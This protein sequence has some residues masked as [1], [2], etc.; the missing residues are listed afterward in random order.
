MSDGR[1]SVKRV[2]PYPFEVSLQVAGHPM[3]VQIVKVTLKG[4]L[5]EMGKNVVKVGNEGQAQFALPVLRNIVAASIKVMRTYDQFRQLKDQPKKHEVIRVAEFHFLSLTDQS[6]S[7]I[8]QFI[9]AI[10]QGE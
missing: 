5:A 1:A 9:G 8:A 6:R 10:G 7:A 4:F 2:N 3:V